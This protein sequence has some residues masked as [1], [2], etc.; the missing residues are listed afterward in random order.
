MGGSGGGTMKTNADPWK[1]AIPYLLGGDD[2]GVPIGMAPNGQMIMGGPKKGKTMTGVF[3]E[4]QRLY[5]ESGW[6]PEMQ[7]INDRYS[8][9]VSNRAGSQAME[10]AKTGA[11][12][13]MRGHFDSNFGPVAGINTPQANLV[14]ARAAQGRLDPTDA[15]L[16]TLTGR[17]DNPYLDKQASAITANLTRNLNE[18]VMPGLRSEALL[19][20]QYGGSRQGIAEGL[21]ASRLNQDL[22]PALTGLYGGAYESAQNRM[23]GTAN[24]LN[25]QAVQ[26]AQTNAGLNMQGQ[27]FNANLGLQNNSQMLQK[28]AQNLNNR[29]QGLNILG[30]QQNMQDS[31][32]AQMMNALQSPQGFEWQNLGQYNSMINPTIGQTSSQDMN[33]NRLA[34]AAGGALTG[35]MLGG[36]AGGALAGAEAGSAVPVYGT[37]IGAVLG[38]LAGAFM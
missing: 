34:G 1:Q 4:A 29:M 7:A 22:A 16:R 14:A 2:P 18:N 30:T 36:A 21:A 26:N 27:Q 13:V 20:G 19:S 6:T 15:L 12:D 25:Q 3:P 24:A 11:E 10:F 33:K 23:A 5:G 35:G 32:Y 38:G 8:G 31:N 37:A 17:P 28:N 9:E